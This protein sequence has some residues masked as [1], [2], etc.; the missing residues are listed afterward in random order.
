M[1]TTIAVL[2][3]IV[4][5]ISG[6]P[7]WLVFIASG[8]TLLTLASSGIPPD[9]LASRMFSSLNVYALLAV[10]GFIFAAELMVR[11]GMSQRLINWVTVLL[12]RVPGGVPVTT[13]VASEVFGAISGSSTATVAGIGKVLYPG[14][15]QSAYNESFSLGLITSMGAIAVIV[16]PS[17]TMILYGAVASASVGD[18]FLAG[19]G[20]AILIGLV[21]TLY[22]VV[23][24]LTHSVTS[25]QQAWNAQE[26]WR[27]TREAAWTLGAPVIIFGGIYSGFFTPTE[28]SMVLSVYALIVSTCIYKDLPWRDVWHV[29]LESALL[30]GKIFT[31][32]AAASVFSLVLVFEHIP[33]QIVHVLTGWD[34]SPL[35]ILLMVNVILLIAGMFMDPNSAIVVLVPL[36]LPIAQAAGIDIIHFGIIMTVNLAIGMFT[37]PF[38]LNLFVSTSIFNV[39]TGK[40]IKGVLPFIWV[41]IFALAIIS[42][43][44]EISLFIPNLFH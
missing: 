13:I 8:F 2:V 30:T 20:P 19:I 11:G 36:L 24:A 28:A 33:E 5:L 44:P 9:M 21:V 16:P 32:V 4:L 10:P 35:M 14:L 27:H 12:G 26:V 6:F 34:M 25:Q 7:L 37:P 41:Y 43:V 39:S 1:I 23:Y 22:C 29:A 15:R 31:I 18:L 17:I 38:G 42:Y 3:L 40:V